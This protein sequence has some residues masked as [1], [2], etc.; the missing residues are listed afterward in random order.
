MESSI[1]GHRGQCLFLVERQGDYISADWKPFFFFSIIDSFPQK[2]SQYFSYQKEGKKRI[3]GRPT[4]HN[5]GHPLDRKQT[6]CKGGLTLFFPL[7]ISSILYF[8]QLVIYRR[9][10]FRI[11]EYT[12]FVR[13]CVLHINSDCAF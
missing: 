13:D 2:I 5:F 3:R 8:M 6:I 4:C 10:C 7:I 1:V 9:N 12:D 11:I